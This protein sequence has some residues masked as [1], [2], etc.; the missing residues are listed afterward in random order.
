[1][2]ERIHLQIV[3][4]RV[5]E[6]RRFIQVLFGPRQVGKTTLVYQLLEKCKIPSHFASADAVA[7]SN[8]AW[9]EQQ[10]ETARLKMD[11]IKAEEFLL[12][13]DEIQKIGNWSETVKLLW[14]TDTRTKRA[15]KVILLGSSR[16]LLQ[17]GL[18]ESLAGRFETTYMGH[19]SFSEMEQ[20][21]GWNSNQYVWFGGYPG[22]APLISDEQRWKA[23]VQQALIETSI[24]KDILMLTRIDKP[25]LMKRLFE[26]GCLY[27][28]QILSYNK[29]IGELQDAGNTTTLSHYLDLLHTAGLLAGIEKFSGNLIYKRSSSP[30]FQ[31]HNTALISGQSGN[32]FEEIQVNP[33]AWGRQVESSVGA[34]L[35]NYSLVEGFTVSYWRERNDEVDF[36][37]ERKGQVIGLEIKSGTTGSTAG[38]SAFKKAF[39]PDKV[40]MIGAS[41]TPWQDFLKINPT[42][43]F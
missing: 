43:L 20:A 36:V 3:T 30:K 8:D 38:I 31:V 39:N 17:Q 9:L 34:H 4:K 26:L 18:S 24:S 42:E 28:G 33:V 29:M 11:Q 37:L 14:D 13:I 19:W 15:M 7:A 23:Y 27:S 32:S 41:G 5:L 6:P 21:F 25:A 35:I 22:S 16:L 1:M 10:W 40:L 2:F 12:V